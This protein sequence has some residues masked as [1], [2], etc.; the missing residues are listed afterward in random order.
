MAQFE[1]PAHKRAALQAGVS[2][3]VVDAIANGQR[4]DR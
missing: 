1:W 3:A 2:P 4:V